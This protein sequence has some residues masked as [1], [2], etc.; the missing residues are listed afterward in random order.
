MAFI[1]KQT[2][3]LVVHI[4]NND[5]LAVFQPFFSLYILPH[6]SVGLTDCISIVFLVLNIL[7]GLTTMLPAM[8]L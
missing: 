6:T 5:V 8:S 3:V 2:A 4:N 7:T 1:C